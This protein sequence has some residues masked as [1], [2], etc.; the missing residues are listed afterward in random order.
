[1]G[2][3][4]RG[5]VLL[6][7][8]DPDTCSV[9]RLILESEGYRV[10]CAYDGLDALMKV[11]LEAAPPRLIV[12]DLSMPGVDGFAFR[13][14]K[15]KRAE[16]SNVPIVVVSAVAAF[17]DFSGVEDVKATLGKPVDILRLLSEVKTWGGSPLS[18]DEDAAQM[19]LRGSGNPDSA[20]T[21]L[22]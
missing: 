4:T 20:S 8:D 7:E 6:V 12:M 3:A 1:M 18:D 17:A 5:Y 16:L 19:R 9:Y 2:S 21:R 10:V 14:M 22:Q 11:R 13:R 15:A